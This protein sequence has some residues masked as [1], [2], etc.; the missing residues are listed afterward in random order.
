MIDIAA[1]ALHKS[2]TMV[3][4][5]DERPRVG[6]TGASG[7]VGG[8]LSA[9]LAGQ[10]YRVARFVRRAANGED[11]IEWDPSAG[12][13]DPSALHGLG[14]V[15]HLAGAN[16]AEERW[17]PQRKQLLWD[18]RV[19]GTRTLARAIA[20]LPEPPPVWISASGIGYYGET[21]ER[22]VAEGDA[23]G[24]DFLAQLCV[25]WERETEAVRDR[26]RVVHGRIGLALSDQGGALAKMLPFFRAGLG[27]R[28]GDGRQYISWISLSDL[29]RAIVFC[30]EQSQIVGPV[31]LV[32]PA[33]VTNREFTRT[34]AA[35]LNRPAWLPVPSFAL[36]VA[37]GE[38][39][40]EAL[41]SHRV[42]P[43]ALA[44]HGFR[45]LHPELR[46]ALE[47]SISGL[48]STTV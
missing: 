39:A 46:S 6:I 12:H 18:S 33:P 37:F 24:D 32:A 5:N 15:V 3:I 27:G 40:T 2:G 29:A 48:P 10:G 16:V 43:G 25:A 4:S 8:A 23:A 38:L 45:F 14:A 31:N 20:A 34:L 21:G 11:E 22:Q 44:K 41:A 28:V 1:V 7:L 36:R 35:C 19:D 47:A 17:T 42:L 13:L 26:V 9:E 30:I